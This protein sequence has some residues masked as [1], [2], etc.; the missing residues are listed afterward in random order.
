MV[1]VVSLEGLT[2]GP[3]SYD[4]CGIVDAC[5]GIVNVRCVLRACGIK[6]ELAGDM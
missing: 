3:E 5:V 6:I 4:A 2:F 1:P